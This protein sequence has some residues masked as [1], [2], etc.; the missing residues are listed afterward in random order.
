[1]RAGLTPARSR[2]QPS[3]SPRSI[4]H[5]RFP[6]P[7]LPASPRRLGH[8]NP[9]ASDLAPDQPVYPVHRCVVIHEASLP[10][11]VKPTN[12]YELW[13]EGIPG[14]SDPRYTSPSE[15]K[16]KPELRWRRQVRR[17][18]TVILI[19]RQMP[20]DPDLC[21]GPMWG[22]LSAT[23]VSVPE[24][25]TTPVPCLLPASDNRAGRT[26]DKPS[27]SAPECAARSHAVWVF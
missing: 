17:V 3:S 20:A 7:R 25:L 12:T 11:R 2:R 6:T 19:R 5:A 16:W 10:A 27:R 4:A 13:F 9:G 14:N 22:S 1:V 18:M 26:T 23:V 24:P 21:E 15:G 8:R